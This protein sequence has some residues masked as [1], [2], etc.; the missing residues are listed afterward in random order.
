MIEVNVYKLKT[1]EVRIGSLHQHDGFIDSSGLTGVVIDAN[2]SNFTITPKY[3]A[4]RPV[5]VV[6]VD[7]D[8]GVTFGV[9]NGDD[10]VRPCNV[11]VNLSER[12]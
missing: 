11:C 12:M 1:N 10:L 5:F 9:R 8:S 6:S 2:S 4:N 7:P 3:A